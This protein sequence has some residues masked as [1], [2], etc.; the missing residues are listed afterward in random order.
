A[1]GPDG[2]GVSKTLKIDVVGVATAPKSTSNLILSFM[3]SAKSVAPGQ[4]VTLCYQTQNTTS[5]SIQPDSSGRTL[6]VKGCVTEHVNQKT[7]F[8]LIASGPGG[9]QDR[10]SVTVS[11]G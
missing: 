7:Q 6:P 3:S 9:K 2:V 4:E 5:V 8:T 11:V 1:T 10:E